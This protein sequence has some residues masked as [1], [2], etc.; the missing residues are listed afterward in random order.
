MEIII[1]D[2][3]GFC[4]GVKRAVDITTTELLNSNNNI[5]SLGPLIHNPQVV[6]SF[7]EKGLKTIDEIEEIKNGRVIIRSHGVSKSIIDK[8]SDMSLDIIDSTCPYVKSVHKRV[9]EYQNQGYNIVIIGDASHPEIIGINGWCKNQ[10]FIVNSLEEARNLS[11]MDKICVVSQTTNTQEKF[12][13][14]SKIIKEK[15]NKVEI[16]NTICNA[17]NLRQESCKEVSSKVDAMIVIGGYHSSNTNKLVEISKKYCKN[18]YHIETSKELPLQVLSKF[19]KIGIT[20]G[21]ST[22]DW[23]IKEVVETMDNINSNEMMEAIENSFTKIHRGDVLKG[24]VIYVTNNEVM[25]NINYKSDGI[26]NREELSNDPD[27]KPKD[28][29]KV[30]D[31]IDVYVVKLDDGEGNVV[32]SAKRVNDF[33]NLDTVEKIFNDKERVECKVL[34]N[35]KGG[36]SVIVNGVNGFMPASQVSI[37]F[38]SDLSVYKGKVLIAK[39]IDFDR[40]KKRVILSRKEVEREEL[41]NKKKELWATLEVDQV[42]EGTVQRLTDF[43]AFVDLGGVDGLIHISD[44]SWNRVKHPSNVVKEGQKVLVKVL[45]LDKEK[46]RIS[47]GLKQTV[48]EPW[49]AFSKNVSVGDIVEGTVVNLLDFGAFV[50]LKEGVDGLLHVSQISKEHINKPADVL[51]VGEKINI[52]VIDIN[53][54]EKKISLSLKE[55]NEVVEED[56]ILNKEPEMTIGDIVDN[57]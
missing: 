29:Y 47:L 25:V 22:P 32:L 52:K 24:E 6:K 33:K 31:E 36:L 16:F 8:I 5:Y 27:V 53:E 56:I 14:L 49:T 21:A 51:K 54:E 35:I 1:A 50:R 45:A 48:E 3:A 15:G 43:G 2:N 17:T 28:L 7:E 46:G 34:N 4:F 38:V 9:E 30:G 12:E 13:T 23:I 11:K 57:N 20:A 26:I 44:L 19:N 18:V 37:N 42:V 41:N 40:E 10:A 55:V 39:V